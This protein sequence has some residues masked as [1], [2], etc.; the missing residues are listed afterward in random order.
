MSVPFPNDYTL[1]RVAESDSKACN[2]CFKPTSCVLLSSNKVDFFHACEAHLND[3]TFCT[4]EYPASYKELNAKKM[5]LENKISGLN[6][7]IE[8]AQPYAW[9]KLMSGW[10]KPPA[11]DKQEPDKLAKLEDE[12]KTLTTELETVV[13]QLKQ[14]KV[15]DYKLDNGMYKSRIQTYVSARVRAKRQKEV[16]TPG[17]F[18]SAPTG[19]P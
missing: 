4:P 9:T 18:P 10:K 7:Q 1:R 12:K 3:S 15:K 17:F 16:H 11:E 8:Q 14:T 6:K 19:K 13:S 5:E 2:I